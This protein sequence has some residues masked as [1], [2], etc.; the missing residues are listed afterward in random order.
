MRFEIYGKKETEKVTRLRLIEKGKGI[1]VVA[2]D[3]SGHEVPG[4]TL[5]TFSEKGIFLSKG[6]NPDLGIANKEDCL[7]FA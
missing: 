6:I 4:G 3:A 2:V 5:C 1:M 7:R